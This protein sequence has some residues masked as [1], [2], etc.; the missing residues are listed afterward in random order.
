MVYRSANA[1]LTTNLGPIGS[2]C[3]IARLCDSLTS[4]QF[5]EGMWRRRPD[6]NRGW[7]FC[8]FP[9]VLY[10]VESSCSLVAGAPRFSVVS[11]HSW[12]EVGLKFCEIRSDRRRKEAYDVTVRRMPLRL[13][14][15]RGSGRSG[16][17]R[18]FAHDRISFGGNSTS[19]RPGSR[20]ACSVFASDRRATR[21][22]C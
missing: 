20:C 17:G 8:R 11:G 19:R 14:R 2:I 13:R 4:D 1:R 18:V 7:R 16:L 21:S 10:L 9:W 5:L 15:L 3:W 22:R 6:L 12:T